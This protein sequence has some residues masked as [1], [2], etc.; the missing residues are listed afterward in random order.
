MF[1]L[2]TYTRFTKPLSVYLHAGDTSFY[3]GKKKEKKYYASSP[4]FIFFSTSNDC[5]DDIK[6]KT[7]IYVLLV[8]FDPDCLIISLQGLRLNNYQLAVLRVFRY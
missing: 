7:E 1:S 8:T 6:K 5:L 4:N 3:A 2:N